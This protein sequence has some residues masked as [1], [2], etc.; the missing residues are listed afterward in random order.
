MNLPVSGRSQGLVKSGKWT[1]NVHP[2]TVQSVCQ[3]NL[4][5]PASGHWERMTSQIALIFSRKTFFVVLYMY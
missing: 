1:E 5:T 2:G 4:K 3:L